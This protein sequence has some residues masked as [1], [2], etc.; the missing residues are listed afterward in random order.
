MLFVKAL[1]ETS[2]PSIALQG[3]L[4]ALTRMIYYGSLDAFT[5]SDNVTTTE[6]LTKSFPRDA[7]GITAVFL[8]IGTHLML[9][10]TV[11]VLFCALSRWSILDNAW[12]SAAQVSTR[13]TD[14]VMRV[15]TL[16]SDGDVERALKN[17]GIAKQRIPDTGRIGVS[18]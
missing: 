3:L 1:N 5:V 7:H 11:F 9:I 12:S 4:T 10:S 2:D 17:L 16:A 6:F 8:M 13:A 18:A 14:E 15:S